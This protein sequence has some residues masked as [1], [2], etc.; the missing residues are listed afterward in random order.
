[1]DGVNQ[2]QNTTCNNKEQQEHVVI[3]IFAPPQPKRQVPTCFLCGKEGHKKFQCPRNKQGGTRQ[4]KNDSAVA[5][6]FKDVLDKAAGVTDANLEFRKE[7]EVLREELLAAQLSSKNSQDKKARQEEIERQRKE[8]CSRNLETFQQRF[9]RMELER[10]VVSRG[11]VSTICVYLAFIAMFVFAVFVGDHTAAHVIGLFFIFAHIYCTMFVLF[12]I[13]FLGFRLNRYISNAIVWVIFF[14]PFLL[15][16][17]RRKIYTRQIEMVGLNTSMELDPDA[18]LNSISHVELRNPE[19]RGEFVIK[20]YHTIEF[21]IGWWIFKK[22]IYQKHRRI[23][24]FK[25]DGSED[26][27]VW[28]FSAGMLAELSTPSILGVDGDY[29]SFKHRCQYKMNSEATVGINKYLAPV[30][31]IYQGTF[32]LATLMWQLNKKKFRQLGF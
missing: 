6:Q 19:G 30:D 27:Q 31:N 7:N 29:E 17:G 16:I 26:V 10:T 1:M 9:N 32:V 2:T 25:E 5:D 11:W 4:A 22:V 28:T 14:F 23:K 15:L 20:E 8:F 24:K 13:I 18:R 21:S 12:V 3:D